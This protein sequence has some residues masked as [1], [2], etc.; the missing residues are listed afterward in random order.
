MTI[1]EALETA[2]IERLDA[3]ILLCHVL[4]C[5]RESLIT[6]S[7]RELTENQHE[8]L[9]E[10]YKR[11]EALEPVAYITG[12]KEFYGRPFI[13]TSDVLIPRP[14]TEGLVELALDF[15]K[16]GNSEVRDIDTD[17]IAIAVPLG[18][19]SETKAMLDVGTGS[20]CIAITLKK[21][22][23][24]LDVYG[25]DISEEAVEVAKRNA[26]F[27]VVKIN[28]S[29]GSLLDAA[30]NLDVPFIVVSN[31]PYIP[32]EE[33]LMKDVADYEPSLALFSGEDGGDLVRELLKQAVANPLCRG[34]VVECKKEHQKL[35]ENISRST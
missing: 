26:E 22:L 5:S 19:V 18:D 33:P 32:E 35:F 14:A 34:V 21:Q 23:P 6:Q 2:E 10:L 1:K 3:E 29:K 16:T 30:K 11:R 15:I 25:T 9:Q 8:V 27:S 31:P 7:N 13:V 28:N 24:E 20:G 4:E 17:V 12:T